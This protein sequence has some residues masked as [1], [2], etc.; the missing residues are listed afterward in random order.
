[1]SDNQP[2]LNRMIGDR[3]RAI[4]NDRGL[5]LSQLSERTGGAFSKSRISNY[6][7]G[8][9]RLSIEGAQILADALGEVSAA[10]LL[11]LD[12]EASWSADE[13]RLINCFRQADQRGK[14]AIM[15]TVDSECG[16][17]SAD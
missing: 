11:C 5:S 1:M 12:E 8:I 9:R 16:E 14:R 3:L 4:R 10:H 2:T 6:E 15:D 7:Q 13:Q 17:G